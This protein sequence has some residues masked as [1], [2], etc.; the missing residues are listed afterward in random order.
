[1]TTKIALSALALLIAAPAFA[2]M[3]QL[4]RSAGVAD[5]SYTV[6]QLG[7]IASATSTADAARLRAFYAEEN[8]NASDAMR[9]DVVSY[10]SP[11]A[12]VSHAGGERN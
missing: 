2:G 10:A 12:K 6:S 7:E 11:A 9:N 1:M 4:E 5:G 8:K 3:T